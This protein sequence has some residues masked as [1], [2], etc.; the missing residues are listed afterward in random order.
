MKAAARTYKQIKTLI[1][2]LSTV[3]AHIIVH[4]QHS[5]KDR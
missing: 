5:S 3:H 4:N 2:R 1:N